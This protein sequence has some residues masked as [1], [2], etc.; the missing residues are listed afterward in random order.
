MFEALV[1][2]AGSGF[3]LG[4]RYRPPALVAASALA[5]VIGPIIAHLTGASL[6]I[7]LLASVGAVVAL[8]CGYLGGSLLNFSITRSNPGSDVNT[9]DGCVAAKK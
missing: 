1:V 2:A 5:A 4:L 9:P 6:W 7:V 3:L 8:Q